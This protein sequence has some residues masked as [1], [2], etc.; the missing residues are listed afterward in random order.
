MRRTD[1]A[2]GHLEEDSPAS[3]SLRLDSWMCQQKWQFSISLQSGS[4]FQPHPPPPAS[5]PLLSDQFL[6]LMVEIG[7]PNRISGPAGLCQ[8]LT[9]G[10]HPR[11]VRDSA[12]QPYDT[13]VEEQPL[14]LVS[15]S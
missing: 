13:V 1:K 14:F 6:S 5:R 7:S 4:F 11:R 10:N 2:S 9:F 15:V 3:A 12:L 8:A